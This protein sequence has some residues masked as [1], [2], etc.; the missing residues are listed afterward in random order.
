MT[1]SSVGTFGSSTA[2]SGSGNKSSEDMNSVVDFHLAVRTSCYA[3][4]SQIAGRNPKLACVDI[5][6]LVLLFRLLQTEDE[7]ILGKLYAAL[8]SVRR[9][10]QG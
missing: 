2:S 10:H 1:S 6:L 7:R 5:D 9:A 4:V 8:E 3:T